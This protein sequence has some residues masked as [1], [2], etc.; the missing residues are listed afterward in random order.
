MPP[1][2][3]HQDEEAQRALGAEL[4]RIRLMRDKTLRGVASRTE[5]SPG[6]LHKLESGTVPL[7]S[8]HI[9]YALAHELNADYRELFIAAGYPL[10]DAP[11]GATKTGVARAR[12]GSALAR[13]LESEE[14]SDA[15]AVELA[16]YLRFIRRGRV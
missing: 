2:A 3:G 14:V 4:K 13:A 10:P 1:R 7:P 5:L 12:R 9:L 15:E 6:Y 16:N 8:P 11:G